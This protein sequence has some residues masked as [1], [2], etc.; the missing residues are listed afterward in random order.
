MAVTEI[1]NI[2]KN[3]VGVGQLADSTGTT[4]NPKLTVNLPT[5]L[6]LPVT[7]KNIELGDGWH[8]LTLSSGVTAGSPA[9]ISAYGGG[10]AYRVEGGNHVYISGNVSFPAVNYEGRELATG[11][12]AAYCPANICY[13]IGFGE[14]STGSNYKRTFVQFYVT[15]DGKIR[16]DKTAMIGATSDLTSISSSAKMSWCDLHLDYWID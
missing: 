8:A 9:G 10:L 16:C 7:A 11:I 13:G 5:T 1:F 2:E 3:G 14:N 12:P 15:T 6:K 4:T